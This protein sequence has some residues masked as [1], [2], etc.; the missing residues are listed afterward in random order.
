MDKLTIVGPRRA[1]NE[2]LAA[3]LRTSL[4]LDDSIL[5]VVN[6]EEPHHVDKGVVL[7]DSACKDRPTL[8]VEARRMLERLPRG[9][10]LALFNVI[11]ND[12][13]EQELV[14]MGVR[15]VFFESDTPE[16]L[17]KGAAALLDGEV[18]ASRK[19]LSECLGKTISHIAGE[20]S[21]D[22][23]LLSPREK[24]VLL[25]IARGKSD[26]DIADDLCISPFTVKT[27]LYRIFRKISVTNRLQAA[28]WAVKNL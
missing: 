8:E 14:T 20:R 13:L 11:K 18:W 7:Y 19:T 9:A 2:L 1:Q 21:G 17:N 3:F 15:G 26:N 4:G 16:T 25:F 6:D 27:H 28:L 5:K 10:S 24:E 12:G 22:G 23:D